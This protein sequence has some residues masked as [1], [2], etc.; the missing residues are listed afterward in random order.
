MQMKRRG[1]NFLRMPMDV[2]ELCAR[3]ALAE[4]GDAGAV[5]RILEQQPLGRLLALNPFQKL[6]IIPPPPLDAA[7]RDA[8][9]MH[10][11]AVNAA[12]MPRKK[13]RV[14]KRQCAE[15]RHP[16]FLFPRRFDRYWDRVP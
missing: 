15:T 8:V 5:R 2:N 10:R 16:H 3:I 12:G 6:T 4:C 11:L 9:E 14:V 13:E 7:R 1:E